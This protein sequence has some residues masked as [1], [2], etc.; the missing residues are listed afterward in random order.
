VTDV[1]LQAEGETDGGAVQEALCVCVTVDDFAV[2]A[3]VRNSV[4]DPCDFDD[5]VHPVKV[6]VAVVAQ[7]G[8][9]TSR[10]LSSEH[11]GL[12]GGVVTALA[13]LTALGDPV[14]VLADVVTD[15]EQLAVALAFD[16]VPHRILHN[17]TRSGVSMLG[18]YS[19]SES[20]DIPV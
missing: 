16:V 3:E 2:L 12:L 11:L 8:D 10:G 4:D 14:G 6:S 17:H 19:Q 7:G 1:S 15:V 5:L 18:I 13:D 9:E 20:P